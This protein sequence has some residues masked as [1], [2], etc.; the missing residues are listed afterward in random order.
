M[1]SILAIL[2]LSIGL[3]AGAGV[4]Q[5]ADD[6]VLYPKFQAGMGQQL[7]SMFSWFRDVAVRECITPQGKKNYYI[8]TKPQPV[9]FGVCQYAE[10][11]MSKDKNVRRILMMSAPQAECPT[12]GSAAYVPVGNVTPGV[13]L[14]LSQYWNRILARPATLD[15]TN[16]A[17]KAAPTFEGLRQAIRGKVPMRLELIRLETKPEG[18]LP[19]YILKIRGQTAAWLLFADISPKGVEIIGSGTSQ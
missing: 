3:V 16:D 14:A 8:L 6:C 18:T 9:R 1:R 12:A 10:F 15:M 11:P 13:F 4:A 2:T 19:Y 17:V 5:A 7:Q